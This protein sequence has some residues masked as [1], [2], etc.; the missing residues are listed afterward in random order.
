MPQFLQ[1]LHFDIILR[2]IVAV[3]SNRA[4]NRALNNLTEEIT[5]ISNL[6]ERYI[7]MKF[8]QKGC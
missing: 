3:S 6:K 4:D 1:E 8:G 7:L 5:D 2:Y